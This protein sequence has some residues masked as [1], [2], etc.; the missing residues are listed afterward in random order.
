VA[1]ATTVAILGAPFAD[2][3]VEETVLRPRGVRI[4]SGDGTTTSDVVAQSHGASV[5]L[6]GSGPRFDAWVI[7]RL[8]CIGIVRYGVGVETIDLDAAARAGKW[9][10][11]VP[12]YGT[13]AV[14]THS[15]SL[16]LAA[17]RRL[18]I[19]D[20]KVKSGDWG[21]GDLRPL[22]APNSVTVGIVGAGRIGARVAELLTPFGFELVA[23]DAYVDI[24]ARMPGVKS[25][26]LD[27]LLEMSDVVTLHA[28]GS[29]DGTP[30][31]GADRLNRLKRGAILVN[32]ARGSL[33]DQTALVDRLRSGAIALAALDVFETEPPGAALSEVADRTILTPHMAWY[34]EQSEFDLRTKAAHEALRLLDGLPPLNAAASP[35]ES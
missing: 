12:D 30:L 14:A 10:A 27:E 5:V 2:F 9:V 15:V 13:D 1:E 32:T 4:V 25:A 18:H 21:I 26:T 23:H 22:Q 29:P 28:F 16:I 19:A 20:K 31:L 6:A 17:I 3:L 8:S 33:I 7:A 24:G 35:E 11:H 34:T